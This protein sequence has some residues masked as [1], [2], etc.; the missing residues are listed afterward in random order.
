MPL[1]IKKIINEN[2]KDKAVLLR[3]D[4]NIPMLDGKVTDLTRVE[5]LI[6]TIEYLKLSGA[7]VIICSHFGRP[8][9]EINKNYSLKPLVDILS[10]AVNAEIKFAESCIGKEVLEA[11]KLLK[12]GEILLL[13]NVRFN[14]G[15]ANNDLVF[16][17]E[18]SQNCDMFVNDAFSCSHRFH[19]SLHAI[20]KFLPS[21]SGILLNEELNALQSV[22]SSPV[23]PVA[24]LVGGAKISTKISIIEYLLTKMDYLIIGGAMANTFMVAKGFNV[25]KSLYEKDSI[26]IAKFILEK[27][28]QYK[29]QIIL[30]TD[31][32]VAHKFEDKADTQIV[33]SEMIP[34]DMMALDIGPDSIK[35]MSFILKNIKT[36][37]WNGPL[38][39]FEIEGFEQGTFSLAKLASTLT[40]E[41]KLITVAGGGDTAFALNKAGVSEKFTYISLAGGAFL[42]WL[43]GIELPGISVLSNNKN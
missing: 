10:K 33:S 25:G 31:F 1:S 37:L 15:E 27:S 26:E 12:S 41:G 38:G 21:Y 16:A 35:K 42:E 3:A 24:A 39:A 19:A 14:K 13:E 11:K 20:T 2:V 6:P 23:K 40:E 43:E 29:C 7:K 34:S 4:L 5:R 8:N 36:L 18:L 28:K 32:V 22:V 17:D 9:G 30:P